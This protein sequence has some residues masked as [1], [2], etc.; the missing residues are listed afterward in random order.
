[1]IKIGL[2]GVAPIFMAAIRSLVASLCLFVW[3]HV[4]G[5]PF[6][7]ESRFF[8]HGLTIGVVFAIEFICM[9]LGINYTLA[10]R[11]YILVYT[12]PFFV[13]LG[14]IFSSAGIDSPSGRSSDCS[15]LSW[16]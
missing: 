6:F 12:A 16:G 1:M 5:I 7:P 15:S 14:A 4:R 8:W 2:R 3:M 13:A 10:S 11:S 9:F